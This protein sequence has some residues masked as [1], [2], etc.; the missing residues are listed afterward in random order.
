MFRKEVAAKPLTIWILCGMTAPVVQLLAG[1]DF[2]LTV[3]IGLACTAV[4]CLGLSGSGEYSRSAS[5]WQALFLVLAVAVCAWL[6]GESWPMGN[7]RR[8]V[9]W[10]LLGLAAWSAQ[11]GPAVA[12]RMAGIL[13]II[14]CVGYGLVIAAGVAQ[15]DWEWVLGH[16]DPD[17]AMAVFLFLLPGAGACLPRGKVNKKQIWL[18]GIPLLSLAAS[19]VTCGS[20]DPTAQTEN[21]PFFEM[22]RSLSLFGFAERFEA[23]VCALITVGWFSLLSF[24]LSC[25][26]AAVQKFLP[27]RAQVAVWAAAI[28]AGISLLGKMSISWG[29]LS[30]ASAVFWGF[31]PLL[32]QVLAMRKKHGK[33]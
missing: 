6:A 5:G 24:L 16:R 26:G 15:T 4:V 28:A 30:T 7:T 12:A 18:F 13:F 2:R 33:K 25:F 9:P 32:T 8:I 27:G 3:L 10:V 11:R 19:V 23:L 22:C 17:P 14:L 21:Y 1:G 20:V 31:S 29:L